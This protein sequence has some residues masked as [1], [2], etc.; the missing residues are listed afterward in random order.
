[1]LD[2]LTHLEGELQ[3]KDVTIAALKVKLISIRKLN[4]DIKN[5]L[6]FFPFII[7]I[8]YHCILFTFQSECLKHV[9]YSIQA[10]T[11]S[12]DVLT[13]P[14]FAL[15]RDAVSVSSGPSPPGQTTSA[16]K[17]HNNQ[18]P[19]GA[20]AGSLQSVLNK[21]S[22]AVTQH[23]AHKIKVLQVCVNIV[24]KTRLISKN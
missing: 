12:G 19:N 8:L 4:C 5:N 16:L 3:A 23:V 20:S 18:N 11:K 10:S 2:V 13:D 14:L 6:L 1:M 15:G 7:F 21:E 9:I 24:S 22:D 17:N